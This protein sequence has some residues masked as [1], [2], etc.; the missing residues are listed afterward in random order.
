VWFVILFQAGIAMNVEMIFA[1]CTSWIIRKIIS[2]DQSNF[3][4]QHQ[5]SSYRSLIKCKLDHL[6]E[7]EKH[8]YWR[9]EIMTD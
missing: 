9:V 1:R 3:G 4:E 6:Y 7:Q 8:E 5:E 2:V